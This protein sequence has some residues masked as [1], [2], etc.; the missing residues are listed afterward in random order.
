M[1]GN[2]ILHHTYT[3]KRLCHLICFFFFGKKS[4]KTWT[5]LFHNQSLR[6]STLA[7]VDAPER[8]SWTPEVDDAAS[9]PKS[10][11]LLKLDAHFLPPQILFFF[12]FYFASLVFASSAP[13][14]TVPSR[15]SETSCSP[16]SSLPPP[17]GNYKVLRSFLTP[18][19]WAPH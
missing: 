2:D 8:P 13:P 6:A 5:K 4:L 16:A 15:A 3:Y 9:A 7:V 1:T 19:S 18:C 11:Q 10:N 17:P 14:I 12:V